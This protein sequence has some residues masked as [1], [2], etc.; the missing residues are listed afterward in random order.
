MSLKNQGENL[1]LT[2]IIYL[3]SILCTIFFHS[4]SPVLCNFLQNIFLN[5]LLFC[6]RGCSYIEGVGGQNLEKSAGYLCAA[7]CIQ[8]YT[9]SHK[10]CAGWVPR[11]FSVLT[12]FFYSVL[13]FGFNFVLTWLDRVV[14]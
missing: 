8:S 11:P 12:S 6:Y 7:K 10:I 5:S 2:N 3:F 4:T 13:W 9:E 1:V 14:I